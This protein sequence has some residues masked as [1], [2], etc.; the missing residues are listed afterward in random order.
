MLTK[1][2]CLRALE[3]IENDEWL[4]TEDEDGDMIHVSDYYENEFKTLRRLIYEHFNNPQ[5]KFEKL[6]EEMR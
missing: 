3:R 1:E 6:N 5:L 2:E 4:I